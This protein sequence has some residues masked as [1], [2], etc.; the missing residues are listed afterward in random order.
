MEDMGDGGCHCACGAG[1]WWLFRVPP[2]GKGGGLL[3]VGA[4]LMPL[5]W[6]K[7]ASFGRMSWV[8]M[9]F[10]LLAVE[11]R[12]INKEHY[13]NAEAQKQTLNKLEMDFTTFL[14]QSRPTSPT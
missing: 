11:Y 5:F 7:M 3:A 10:V 1:A 2:V 6:D 14:P 9:L 13:E 4:T 12:A 8:F